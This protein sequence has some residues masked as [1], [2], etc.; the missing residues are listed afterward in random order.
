MHAREIN[1]VKN[2]LLVMYLGVAKVLDKSNLHQT[3]HSL[4]LLLAAGLL[5]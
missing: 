2:T 1:E 5:L 3:L 4:Q